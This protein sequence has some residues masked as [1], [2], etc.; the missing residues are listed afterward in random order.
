MKI[1]KR[2]LALFF[3]LTGTAGT[4]PLFTGITETGLIE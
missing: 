4:I 2:A 1:K 3:L